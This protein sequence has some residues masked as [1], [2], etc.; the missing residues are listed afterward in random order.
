MYTT[1]CKHVDTRVGRAG[2]TALTKAHLKQGS[3]C[4][5]GDITSAPSTAHANKAAFLPTKRTDTLTDEPPQAQTTT[6]QRECRL[7]FIQLYHCYPQSG[8]DFG[9]NSTGR[10][11]NSICNRLPP[12]CIVD[13]ATPFLPP[14]GSSVPQAK[15]ICIIHR[16]AQGR[17]RCDCQ[18]IT[19]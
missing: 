8:Y 11:P 18:Q 15:Q 13:C 19:L 9:A 17:N 16:A 12:I 3:A 2:V 7:I 5:A 1:K 4:L 14:S 6:S 10:Y